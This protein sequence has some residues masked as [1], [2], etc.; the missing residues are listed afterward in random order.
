MHYVDIITLLLTS[1]NV[2]D[3]VQCEGNLNQI[4]RFAE[5][6]DNNWR[7]ACWDMSPTRHITTYPTGQVEYKL[8]RFD[9]IIDA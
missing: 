6:T 1:K 9:Y 7:C 4:E 5:E 2:I 8:H 3:A